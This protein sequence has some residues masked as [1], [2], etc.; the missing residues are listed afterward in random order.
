M[1]LK[2]G[3]VLCCMFLFAFFWGGRGKGGGRPCTKQGKI[4][5]VVSC[6]HTTNQ[7]QHCDFKIHE[8]SMSIK[9]KMCRVKGLQ[10]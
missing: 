8:K 9:Q 5:N 3:K 7:Q 4:Q 6:A 1:G 10:T 2:L